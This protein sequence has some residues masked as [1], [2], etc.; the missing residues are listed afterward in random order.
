MCIMG[1]LVVLGDVFDGRQ[2]IKDGYVVVD[3]EAGVIDSVGRRGDLDF[4][5]SARVIKGVFIVPG[6]VD[7]HVH[8][9]GTR[10]YSLM[11]WV[12]VPETLAALRSVRDLQSLLL[13][14]FTTVRDMGSKGGAYLARALREGVIQGPR[15]LSCAKSLGQTGGD[16]DPIN[17]P[18][19]VAEELS[20]SY[21]CDGPWGCRRAVRLVLRDGADFVKVYCATG[22][23]PEPKVGSGPLIRPQFTVDELRAIVDEAHRCGLRVAAH[24]I[25][26]ESLEN[27]VEAGVDSLEHGM[28]LTDDLAAIIKKKGIYY[29]PTLSIFTES[30]E[31][32]RYVDNPDLGDPVYVRHHLTRDMELAK[33]Y[34]LKVVCGSDFGGTL[35]ARHGDNYKEIVNLSRYIGNIEA[36]RASTV[37][38]A[39]CLGLDRTGQIREGFLADMVVLSGDP[40]LSAHNL[41]PHM[42]QCVVKGGVVYSKANTL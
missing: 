24:T 17:L 32:M 21:Y 18:L 31:F 41:A 1:K 22:S 29:V 2:T 11:S 28:G 33:N 15:V 39:E 42:V 7:A 27:A 9:F 37:N 13:S 25:G 36:L 38:A 40:T 8:F 35:N 23:T 10:E 20:Y 6:L 16:D 30:Q 14:G 19:D 12:S 5:A 26:Q 34:S 3:E 4:P